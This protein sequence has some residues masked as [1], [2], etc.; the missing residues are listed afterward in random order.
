[1]AV[2]VIGNNYYGDDEANIITG[3]GAANYIF[4]GLGDDT[5][6]GEGGNDTIDGGIG[7]DVIDGGADDDRLIDVGSIPSNYSGLIGHDS[8]NGG[9]GNDHIIFNSPDTGDFAI[10]GNGTDTISIWFN[11]STLPTAV[12]IVFALTQG[13]SVATLDGINTVFVQGIERLNFAGNIGNDFI[14]GGELDDYIS[15]EGGN[16]TLRGLGGNDRLDGGTGVQDIDGGDGFDTVSFDLTSATAGFTID[17]STDNDI[18]LG[19]WGIIKGSEAAELIR[20]GSGNDVITNS[21]FGGE[22]F[23]NG[24]NDQFTGGTGDEIWNMGSG[25]DTGE[26]GDGSDQ[27]RVEGFTFDTGTK[28]VRGGN[29][30]DYL[31]GA[32][33]NDFL[34]GD[35]DNDF[36]NGQNG[37]DR[38]EGGDGNDT[39]HGGGGDDYLE[40]GDGNDSFDADHDDYSNTDPGGN[41][42]MIGGK[43]DDG[44]SG[45]IGADVVEGGEGNDGAYFYWEGSTVDTMKDTFD[46]GTG[47]DTFSVGWSN[48]QIWTYEFVVDETIEVKV[49]N[50]LVATAINVEEFLVQ[51]NANGVYK[52][53]GSDAVDRFRLGSIAEGNDIIKTFG[54]NDS[55]ESAFGGDTI[56]AGDG[57]DTVN[58]I[59]GGKDNVKAGEGND[60][61]IIQSVTW[62]APETGDVG[63]YDLGKGK[64]TLE[65][66]SWSNDIRFE[67]GKN[68]LFG[69]E[70]IGVVTGWETLVFHA[71][72]LATKF[73]GTDKAEQVY[74]QHLNDNAKMGGGNDYIHDGYGGKDTFDGGDGSDTISYS[75]RF[76]QAV[77]VTLNGSKTVDVSVAGVDED[78]I[79]NFENVQGGGAADVLT[80][81]KLRNTLDGSGGN[82]TLDGADGNDIL[83][84]ST[85]KDTLTGGK[86]V[87]LFAYLFSNTSGLGIFQRDVIT[88]FEKG[89][90]KIDLSKLDPDGNIGN[91]TEFK[92]SGAAFTGVAGDVRTYIDGG[93]TIVEL[94]LNGNLIADM[95]IELTGSLNL[96]KSDFLL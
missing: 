76:S 95:Q 22:F 67:K 14:Q 36:L 84:G 72:S 3:T 64:D 28:N 87:D 66:T 86:G 80:G 94:D 69:D 15:G 23:T 33:G 51:G 10:G 41:D 91:A 78:K 24:G 32:A 73:V 19:A 46:G 2:T 26:M 42:T 90:D 71:P 96:G 16:D 62:E 56:D 63:K 88:D 29:G 75:Y 44:F 83:N 61:L 74:F 81:D 30:N 27:A 65:I 55:I 50:I 48:N 11:R 12:P 54:G 45:G 40:G 49:N 25:N 20:T 9:E 92:F 68:L 37:N 7:H 34:Y 53:T 31:F 82:D 57:D 89:K 6:N 59:M 79:K 43:G 5:L 60:R 4:G 77:V 39:L 52:Y 8:I 18:N 17:F 38:L 21:D 58:V 1:M 47:R 70:L 93:I 13:G 35:G 85:G